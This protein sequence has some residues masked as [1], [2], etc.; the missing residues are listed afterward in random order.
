MVE[1][2]TMDTLSNGAKYTKGASEKLRQSTYQAFQ[3]VSGQAKL[4]YR[5]RKGREGAGA[6]P[7]ERVGQGRKNLW[8]GQPL[9]VIRAD[10]LGGVFKQSLRSGGL[11]DSLKT[12]ALCTP[13]QD[14]TWARQSNSEPS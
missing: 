11:H 1:C 7:K 9:G 5:K 13:M 10:S 2:E 12:N 6:G 4:T 8:G 14:N 3:G